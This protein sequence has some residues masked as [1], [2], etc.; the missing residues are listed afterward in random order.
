[1]SIRNYLFDLAK[2]VEGATNA[3]FE[4]VIA[5]GEQLATRLKSDGEQEGAK[6]IK[7]IIS[8][9]KA[10]RLSLARANPRKTDPAIP[11]DGE[12]RLAV[13]DEERWEPDAVQ[14]FLSG[15]QEME[16]ARFLRCVM[17]ADELTASGVGI[18][19][20]LIVYG[21]P[22]CGKTQL[23]RYVAAQL[24]LP[25]LTARADALI[26]SYL[27]STSKNIRSLFEH[28]ASRRCVLFLD[29]F[30]AIAKMRD[31]NRE[32][33][34]LKRVVISLLQNIDSLGPDHLL[35]AATNHEHL[36]DPAIWRRFSSKMRLSE[37]D[38]R[39][40]DKMVHEFFGR[41]A[42]EEQRELFSALLRGVSGAAIRHVADDSIR[43]AVLDGAALVKTEA[44]MDRILQF[45]RDVRTSMSRDEKIA[46]VRALDA[47]RF[48]QPKLAE[49]FGVSQSYVSKVLAAT[50]VQDA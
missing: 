17:S 5:Y 18:S 39:A 45:Q 26:S 4:K 36:L 48:T 46:Y 33:G 44:V 22:G 14:L 25:L 47:K 38:D 19:P 1:M 23:A 37:P 40:R 13:A 49:L 15:E 29:E 10:H 6:R 9:S 24:A 43:D 11:V 20:S 35:I 42:N 41:F 32:L 31:D 21:P 7:E 2:I 50:A 3:D 16:L 30:D 34:E 8:R 12:S 27:G 28:A